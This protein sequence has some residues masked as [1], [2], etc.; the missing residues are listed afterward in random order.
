M[1]AGPL[2]QIQRPSPVVIS[3]KVTVH[4]T[5]SVTGFRRRR[6][7]INKSC[8]TYRESFTVKMSGTEEV[9]EQPKLE[10][11]ADPPKSEEP[12][13]TPASKTDSHDS[14]ETEND[15]VHLENEDTGSNPDSG[16]PKADKPSANQVVD[17][18]FENIDPAADESETTLKSP[19][20]APNARKDFKEDGYDTIEPAV[21]VIDTTMLTDS[22]KTYVTRRALF[23]G[24][25]GS[26]VVGA[27]IYL[28]LH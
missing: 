21:Q 3:R 15:L 14:S 28:K 10:E 23:I 11:I 9:R 4:P 27:L 6:F 2:I 25:V 19:V 17:L 26:L 13:R 24:A 22:D 8:A 18:K 1:T 7:Y 16:T 20:L 12:E 5:V